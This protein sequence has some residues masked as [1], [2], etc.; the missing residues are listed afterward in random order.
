M[1]ESS[2][3]EGGGAGLVLISPHDTPLKY[4]IS[5]YFAISNNQAEYEAL[6]LDLKLALEME[7]LYLIVYSDS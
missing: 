4:V 3:S 6:I 1:D 2:T 7:V 5:L